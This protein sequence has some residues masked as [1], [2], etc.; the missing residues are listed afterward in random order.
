MSEPEPSPTDLELW[1]RVEHEPPGTFRMYHAVGV[2]T[3]DHIKQHIA[4]HDELQRRLQH[5]FRTQCFLET[6]SLRL[7][8]IDFWLRIYFVAHSTDRRRR[9]FGALI[10]Q[11]ASV[12]LSQSLHLRLNDFNRHRINAIHG[13]VVGTTSYQALEAVVTDSDSLL[14]DVV[15]FVVSNS[16]TV[17]TN[18]EQL[19]ARPGAMT[20]HLQGFCEMVRS[21]AM[22]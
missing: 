14:R 19:R 10:E 2:G 8:I 12:G 4:N 1:H 17:V 3:E 21:G 9:E 13:Y 11:C 7:Q 20:L 16:G 5:S 15:I 22:Y 6:I 18:R